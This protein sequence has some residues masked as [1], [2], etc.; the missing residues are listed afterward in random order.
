[1]ERSDTQ[2]TLAVDPASRGDDC[3]QC[4]ARLAADQ[5]YCVECGARRGAHRLALMDGRTPAP[6]Q[7]RPAAPR[8]RGRAPA[9]LT[10]IA[11]ICTLL[12]AV[13]VGVLIGRSD[14][15][16]SQPVAAA[17]V[18]VVTVGAAP[19]A[20][21]STTAADTAASTTPAPART[22]TTASSPAKTTSTAAAPAVTVGSTGHGRGYNKDGKFT[23]D[24]FGGG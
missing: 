11:G 22:T 17:P 4:G 15:S 24:F 18:Q 23:G 21:A 12:V 9:G 6:Q 10:L 13:G 2:T 7:P 5:R 3:A 14:G 16:Q 19:A 20:G 8:Q 1:M